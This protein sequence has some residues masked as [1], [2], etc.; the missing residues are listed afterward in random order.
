MVDRFEEPATAS[1]MYFDCG[2]D[3]RAAPM[4]A[5]V[6]GSLAARSFSP[7]FAFLSSDELQLG[8]CAPYANLRNLWTIR[9]CFPGHFGLHPMPVTSLSN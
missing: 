9:F 5:Y 3:D 2:T 4:M 7:A 6:C 8:R 1:A